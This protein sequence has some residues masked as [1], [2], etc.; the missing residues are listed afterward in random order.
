M[1]KYLMVN[2]IFCAV[3]DLKRKILNFDWRQKMRFLIFRKYSGIFIKWTSLVPKKCPLYRDVR[4]IEIFSK[5]VWPQ[6]KAIRS[7]SYCPSYGGVRFIVCPLYRDSTVVQKRY[8]LCSIRKIYPQYLNFENISKK[9]I[10][11]PGP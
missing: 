1:K 9:C 2:F 7:W 10:R 6:S 8:S 4:F 11:F 3:F 5:V